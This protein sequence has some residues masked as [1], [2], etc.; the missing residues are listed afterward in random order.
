MKMG[1]GGFHGKH[2][3]RLTNQEEMGSG[4]GPIADPNVCEYNHVT[5]ID[6]TQ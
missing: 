4:W 2:H 5:S 3:E 1:T 6:V